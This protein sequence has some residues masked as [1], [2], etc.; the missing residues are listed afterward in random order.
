MLWF[1][2]LGERGLWEESSSRP[3]GL[4][5]V[6]HR[7][8]NDDLRPCKSNS[9]VW[10]LRPVQEWSMLGFGWWGECLE[11]GQCT[12]LNIGFTQLSVCADTWRF[13]YSTHVIMY[14]CAGPNGLCAWTC[15]P[16]PL[17]CLWFFE[18][19]TVNTW[20]SAL[21]SQLMGHLILDFWANAVAVIA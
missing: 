6:V 15:S 14:R 17:W 16:K 8:C 11:W 10:R 5:G 3:R 12:I 21:S 9:V 2:R 1:G 13:A 20:K 18:P 4:H 7:N 19:P